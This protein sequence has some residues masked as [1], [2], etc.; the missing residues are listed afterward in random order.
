MRPV[1]EGVKRAGESHGID[2]DIKTWVATFG[3]VKIGD[4]EIK[5]AKLSIGDTATDAFD[6]L[7]GADFFMAHHVYVANSQ[8][9]LYFTYSG[10][11]VFRST[12]PTDQAPASPKPKAQ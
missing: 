1:T 4:E 10:G 12:A 6:V 7:I 11:P 5:N 2:G 8:G 3:S 9:K